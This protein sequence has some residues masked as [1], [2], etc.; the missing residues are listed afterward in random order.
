MCLNKNPSTGI[1]YVN[2]IKSLLANNEKEFYDELQSQK[3]QSFFCCEISCCKEKY[4]FL[5]V[6]IKDPR[7]WQNLD[8][9]ILVSSAKVIGLLLH[10]RNLLIEDL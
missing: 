6:D 4:G 2:Q 1:F 7:I 3:I 10:E 9:D 8:M 5:R